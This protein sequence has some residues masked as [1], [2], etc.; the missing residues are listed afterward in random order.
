MKRK[1]M[2]VSML[3]LL[4]AAGCTDTTPE[5]IHEQQLPVVSILT[6]G[7]M[8]DPTL[9]RIGEAVSEITAEQLGCRVEFRNANE[10]DYD[11]RINDLLLDNDL[12]DIIFCPDRETLNTLM[13]G[14]YVYRLDRFLSR[15]LRAAVDSDAAWAETSVGEH[16]YGIPLGNGRN[17]RWGF[18][19][20]GDIC[21]ALK[22]NPEDIHDLED[23][24]E[25]L[26]LVQENYPDMIPVVPDSGRM[27]TFADYIPLSSGVGVLSPDGMV[28]GVESMPE[29]SERVN[30]MYNWYQEELI[31]K[32]APFDE[33]SR[34]SWFQS[35]L[36]FGSFARAGRYTCEELSYACDQ[37]ILF[38]PLG[39]VHSDSGLSD[40]C[41]CIY[42]YTENVAQCLDVLELIYTDPQILMLC[43]YG[44]EGVDYTLS[45]SGAAV[46]V[47]ENTARYFSWKWPLRNTIPQPWQVTALPEPTESLTAGFVF[48]ESSLPVET[49]QCNAVM[50][51]YF[52]TLCSGMLEPDSGIQAMREELTEAQQRVILQEKQRQWNTWSAN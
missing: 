26:L 4:F 50:D 1:W 8:A 12:A 6:I 33:T 17:Y 46:P 23:L 49:Y 41:F 5:S 11:A 20:R 32:N 30:I 27:E 37:D 3:M 51:K 10:T 40:G 22:I 44:Q 24:H 48:D 28:V 47:K 18:L 9:A 36:A 25:V 39:P 35:G 29:F 34:S 52:N 2:I 15:E 14:N 43:V 19:M 42:A 31:L 21:Q 7:E 16:C 45:S 38:V 13:D